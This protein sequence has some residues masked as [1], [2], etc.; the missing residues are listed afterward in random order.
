MEELTEDNFGDGYYTCEEE[1]EYNLCK[2][3]AECEDEEHLMTVE[4][5]DCKTRSNIECSICRSYIGP[6]MLQSGYMICKPC[7]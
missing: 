1:C 4:Y 7:K 2:V 5:T 3:C 6:C